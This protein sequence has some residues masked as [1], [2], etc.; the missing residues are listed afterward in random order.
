MNTENKENLKEETLTSETENRDVYT[1]EPEYAAPVKKKKRKKKGL[2]IFLVILVLAAAGAAGYYFWERQQPI[3]TVKT[4]LTDVQKMNFDGMKAQLQSN[5]LS[6]LDNADITNEAY[7]TF[8]QNVNQKMTFSIKKTEFNIINETAS[9]TTK[10]KYIDG[11]DIYK[12]TITEFLKQIVATAFSGQQLTEEETQ[13]KLAALLEEKSAAISNT[14]AET[15]ITYPLIKAGGKWKIVALDGETVKMMSANFTNVQ[16]EI[17]QSLEEM[18]NADA[19]ETPAAPEASADGTIDMSN[20]KF[21]IHYKQHRIAKDFSGAPCLLVYYDYSNNGTAASSAMVDVN[22]QA[23][24]NGQVLTA[25]IPE[26]NDAAIDQF[27]T[28]VQPGQAVSVCQAFSLIDESDVTLQAG[29]AF[30]FGGGNVTSQIL[31]VK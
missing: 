28:E 3:E 20:E 27:M 10:I 18:E 7:K 15:E 12:E 2:I 19:N 14:F 22:L 24:Q 17:N 25:A 16:D 6:A 29:E 23:Y 30:S 9:I 13:Q 8:F 26:S 1:D 31:K 11:S 21:T 4:F 5:D